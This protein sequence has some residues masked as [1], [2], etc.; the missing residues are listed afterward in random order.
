MDE[1]HIRL[2]DGI[3]HSADILQNFLDDDLHEVTRERRLSGYEQRLRDHE[4]N[5]SGFEEFLQRR[6]DRASGYDA[7]RGSRS[8]GHLSSL[9]EQLKAERDEARA[10]AR[11]AA[12]ARDAALDACARLASINPN[13]RSSQEVEQLVEENRHLQRVCQ[14]L[15]AA[16][17]DLVAARNEAAFD[18]ERARE[19][20][21]A[22]EAAVER[23]TAQRDDAREELQH[24]KVEAD[25]MLQD[26]AE[27][28]HMLQGRARR[29][30]VVVERLLA[31]NHHHQESAAAAA[32]A[33]ER[34]ATPR[35]SAFGMTHTRAAI[36]AA[37][38]EASRLPEPERR[39][40]LGQLR[41]KW[42]PDKH[43]VLKE[44]ATEVT[45]LINDAIEQLESEEKENARAHTSDAT[46][47]SSPKEEEPSPHAPAKGESGAARAAPLARCDGGGSRA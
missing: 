5:I 10:E 46:G 14:R 15:Q 25:A 38:R 13:G 20:L 22:A 39:K 29:L 18:C 40:K 1:D 17:R 36:E 21:R 34:A 19:E 33:R 43:E 31:E 32:A 16:G 8:D 35:D 28:I 7:R 23:C 37:V 6:S 4:E 26:A 44:M 47:A 27:H 9:C 42:H 41:L 30:E 2:H 45:K 3:L 11:Q 12:G 24:V